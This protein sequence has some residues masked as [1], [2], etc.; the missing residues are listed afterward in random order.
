MLITHSGNPILYE[1]IRTMRLKFEIFWNS[2]LASSKDNYLFQRMDYVL[3][4]QVLEWCPCWMDS[5]GTTRCW[6][7]K[8][9]NTR[10]HSPSLW[11]VFPCLCAFWIVKCWDQIPKSHMLSLISLI[12]LSWFTKMI[13]QFIPSAGETISCTWGRSLTDIDPLEYHLT[14]RSLFLG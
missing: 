11:N 2:N 8:M 10:Q 9:T 13:W 5:Q 1:S 7:M 12:K 14:P 4:L 6:L 3:Q